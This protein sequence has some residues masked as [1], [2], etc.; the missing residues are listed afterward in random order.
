MLQ[1]I[2]RKVGNLGLTNAYNVDAGTYGVSM[3]MWFKQDPVI[4][5]I[6]HY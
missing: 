3:R 4:S 1:A 2:Y 6:L 5:H